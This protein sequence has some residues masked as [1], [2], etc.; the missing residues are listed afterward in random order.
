MGC[1]PVT[2]VVSS[3]THHFFSFYNIILPN[4]HE[5]LKY[6]Y[7]K[8]FSGAITDRIEILKIV[9]F[10]VLLDISA[11]A[12]QISFNSLLINENLFLYGEK[13]DFSDM[14]GG[15]EVHSIFFYLS[16]LVN[17]LT[18][19]VMFRLPLAFIIHKIKDNSRKLFVVLLFSSVFAAL[20]IQYF[21]IYELF[22]TMPSLFF[23]GIIY[24]LIFLVVGGNKGKIVF[25][26]VIVTVLHLVWDLLAF[27]FF[28]VP[29]IL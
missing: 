29:G 15:F 8:I 11:L 12:L 6:I 28:G 22:M 10:L 17:V 13:L 19:E 18:E 4:M 2:Q 24:S 16:F 1:Q 3:N 23:G 7:I 25:P 21:S 20:H 27:L 5:I 26:L 14:G 9:A